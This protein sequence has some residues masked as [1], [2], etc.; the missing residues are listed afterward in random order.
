MIGNRG[1]ANALGV[2]VA[3]G[4]P[5]RWQVDL[6]FAIAPP[7]GHPGPTDRMAARSGD[8]GLERLRRHPGDLPPAARDLAGIRRHAVVHAD[9]AVSATGS[10]RSFAWRSADPTSRSPLAPGVA[11]DLA[12]GARDYARRVLDVGHSGGPLAGHR[13]VRHDAARGSGRTQGASPCSGNPAPYAD[14]ARRRQRCGRVRGGP[15]VCTNGARTTA[16]ACGRRRSRLSAAGR[17]GRGSKA[18]RTRPDDG[19]EEE[20]EPKEAENPWYGDDDCDGEPDCTEGGF[21]TCLPGPGAPWP[22]DGRR[23]RRR[24]ARSLSAS[25]PAAPATRTTRSDRTD[26]EHGRYISGT[27]PLSYV[28]LFENLDDRDGSGAGG[29]D[30]RSARSEHDGPRRP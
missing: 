9:A 22:R 23:R 19:E 21:N 7:P 17:R 3:I 28:V 4:V 5:R 18:R 16:I 14:A 10:S 25:S 8:D 20:C 30:H 27:D 11:A 12:K 24:R 29:R 13:G 6:K 26:P 15:G 2:P 1:N